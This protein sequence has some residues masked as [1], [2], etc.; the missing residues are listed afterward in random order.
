MRARLLSLSK[1]VIYSAIVSILVLQGFIVWSTSSYGL[2]ASGVSSLQRSFFVSTSHGLENVLAREVKS[3]PDV[4]DVKVG[5]A[6]VS[7]IGTTKSGLA[8]L[9]WLRSGLKLMEKIGEGQSI[10]SKDDLYAFVG[11]VDW[12]QYL[13]PDQT[14]KCDATIGQHVQSDISHSHFTALTIKN[15]IVDQLRDRM[16]KRPD[17]NLE[18]PSLS[19][20][21]YLH[22]DKATLYRIWSGE[23]SLHKRHYRQEMA[24]PT[25][26]SPIH[27]AALREST[28]A[29]LLLLTGLSPLLSS[30][31]STCP[32]IVDPMC[33]SGTFLIEAALIACDTAPGLI[34]Y[35]SRK[36]VPPLQWLDLEG[37]APLFWKDLW[38]DAQQRDLR[39]P[40]VAD[41]GRTGTWLLGNDIHP[42][43]QS[44]V[45]NAAS[46]AGVL[47]LI[48]L[49]TGDAATFRVPPSLVGQH[50]PLMVVT[51]P[52]WNQ[53]L[54][55]GAE[56]SWSALGACLQN[57]P[58]PA[59]AF[60]LTGNPA[61][62]SRL[63]PL[64]PQAAV[65]LNAANTPM[66]FLK[67]SL[68]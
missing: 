63:T 50:R 28:A 16:G 41:V 56:T 32:V 52:P 40:M 48:R 3:L 37:D 68:T 67:Y 10:Q 49:S 46:R 42:G 66:S 62:P 58:R 18:D 7:F 9:L 47:P 22:R 11:S 19:L 55:E 44:L 1:R 35:R 14:F 29:A 54:S 60:V 27:K 15:A 13:S 26:S 39:K 24:S 65:H 17:V 64:Q 31:D 5:K 33:G 4:K 6:G 30:S 25:S 59:M 2:H 61:L 43:A 51:N 20:M 36:D 34:R 23:Q 38:K 21:L 8:S 53:R 45:L 12:T 57:M